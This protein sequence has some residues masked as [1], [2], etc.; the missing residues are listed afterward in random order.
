MKRISSSDETPISGLERLYNHTEPKYEQ[1]QLYI[2][3]MR[4]GYRTAHAG[5]GMS[6]QFQIS[7][8]SSPEILHH[9]VWR[10]WL[11]T[12][13]SDKRW[14]N[15]HFSLPHL[16]HV[17]LGRLGEW[18]VW[19]GEFYERLVDTRFTLPGQTLSATLYINSDTR[20]G[21]GVYCYPIASGW[22]ARERN[23][24]MISL[25]QDKSGIDCTSPFLF[26]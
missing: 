16:I 2:S 12:A 22:T 13:Y 23:R 20:G 17:S 19:I 4:R 15:Y 21:G 10:I 1:E 9:T 25:R 18:T 11:F 8:A 3:A 7:P 24:Q 5:F 6:D 14:E 26:S